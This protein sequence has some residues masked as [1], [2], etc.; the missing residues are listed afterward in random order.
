MAGKIENEA[1]LPEEADVIRARLKRVLFNKGCTH[2][3]IQPSIREVASLLKMD[4]ASLSKFINEEYGHQGLRR[5]SYT[6]L[7]NWLEKVE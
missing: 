2:C 3:Q 7:A 1:I 6:K 4:Y 5:K